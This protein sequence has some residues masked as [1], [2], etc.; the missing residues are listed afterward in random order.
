MNPLR[1]YDYVYYC[2]A[3]FYDRVFD[4]SE[5]REESA[6]LIL[7][8]LQFCNLL[9]LS[10][11]INLKDVITKKPSIVLFILPLLVIVGLNFLRYKR[12]V[13]LE[14]LI[15]RWDNHSRATKTF[16]MIFVVLYCILSFYAIGI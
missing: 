11:L 3:I 14:K 8:L 1:L 9:F 2:I 4:Y 5:S 7:S 13:K 10:T 16:R 12:I 6:I 15:A